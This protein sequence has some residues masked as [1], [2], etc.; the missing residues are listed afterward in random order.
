MG[1]VCV[2]L[3]RNYGAR[4]SDA[5]RFLLLYR[6]GI[7][8]RRP[9]EPVRDFGVMKRSVCGESALQAAKVSDA[10]CDLHG[11]SES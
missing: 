8:S 11:V 6:N 5:L 3:P 4:T 1:P 9:L 10:R 2:P 7:G